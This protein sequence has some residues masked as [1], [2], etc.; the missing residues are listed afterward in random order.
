MEFENVPVYETWRAM[1]K[2][3]TSKY[4]QLKKLAIFFYQKRKIQCK[5]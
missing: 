1:E 2:L 5:I 3:G 4:L